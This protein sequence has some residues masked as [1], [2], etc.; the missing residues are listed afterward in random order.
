[1]KKAI[2]F[3][4]VLIIVFLLETTVIADSD[5]LPTI[6]EALRN[7]EL[8]QKIEVSDNLDEYSVF[9]EELEEFTGDLRMI[10][11]Q[12]EAPEKEFTANKAYPPFTNED[13][14]PE[15]FTGVDQGAYRIWLRSDLMKQIPSDFRADS[16]KDATYIIMA[17]TLYEWD[18]TISVSDYKETDD[19]ELPEFENAE[20]MAL[21]LSNHPKEVESITYYPKFG[22]YS[23][24][25]LYETASKKGSIYDYTYNESMRFAK[26]PEAYEQWDNMTYVAKLE[27]ALDEAEGIDPVSAGGL[28]ELLDFIPEEKRNIWTSC[29]DAGEYSTARH[30]I[31]EYYWSMAEELKN[32]DPSEENKASYDMIISERN[33]IALQLFADY[34]EYSGFERS[35]SSIE[36][37][38]DYMANA[39]T[40][41]LEAALQGIV[42]L[43]S[44]D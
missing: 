42:D 27:T 1:M 23:F 29:I 43:F 7:V 36:V 13:G 11:L 2:C 15:D 8:G 19:E 35:V 30:S 41:W 38:K 12:R 24:V 28:I 37:S 4:L 39:D 17:E 6:D 21:Y 9:N 34:C 25:M 44:N 3:V 22:V 20:E 16:L 32:L 26:N 5:S 18:G 31:N 33:D 10:V 40:E 14:F